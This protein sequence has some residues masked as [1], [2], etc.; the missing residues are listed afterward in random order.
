MT[1]TWAYV[2]IIGGAIGASI[3]IAAFLL[4][5]FDQEWSTFPAWWEATSTAAALAAA[6]VAVLYSSITLDR[7][8]ER[9]REWQAARV[10]AWPGEIKWGTKKVG[11]LDEPDWSQI[12]GLHAVVRNASDLPVTEVLVSFRLALVSV[13]QRGAATVDSS[14]TLG[15]ERLAV[16]PPSNDPIVVHLSDVHR[17]SPIDVDDLDE[18]ARTELLVDLEFRDSAGRQWRREATTGILSIKG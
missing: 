7:E 18:A 5:L 10:A 13:G 17:D 16:L 15:T 2:G 12:H 9:E 14:A 11:G 6:T 8:R 3:C 1:Q 4:N